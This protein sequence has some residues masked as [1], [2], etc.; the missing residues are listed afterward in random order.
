MYLLPPGLQELFRSQQ[1][2]LVKHATD[3]DKRRYAIQEEGA[4]HYID[5]DRYGTY[6]FDSLPREWKI[7]VE[8]YTKDT[9][10]KHGIVPWWLEIMM[11]R[12]TKAFREK[13]IPRVLQNAAEIG[14]YLSDAHVPLHACSNHNGQ[15]TG[16]RGIHGLWE[17]RV[18]E[19]LA[20]AKWNFWIGQAI[21][22]DDP[23]AY[24]WSRILESALASDSVLRLEREL[25]AQTDS[26][27]KYAYEE[28][29]GKLIRQYSATYTR[30]YDSML[31]GMVERRM[32]LSI[33]SVA[34]IWYTCWVLAG[35]PDLPI[36]DKNNPNPETRELIRQLDRLWRSKRQNES[37]HN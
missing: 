3:P 1:P 19:L 20:D 27:K 6:P 34:N 37:E 4:R 10:D 22:I 32:R 29:K 36:P 24:C 5:L 31:G 15:Y 35:Q 30:Q 28:R 9:L 2:Y 13:D 23:S 7:A 14:H 12:L 11:H 8:R 18:P 26:A 17:S 25:N 33:H 16:Q 21:F